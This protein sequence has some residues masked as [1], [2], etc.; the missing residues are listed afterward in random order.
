MKPCTCQNSPSQLC[1]AQ[2]KHKTHNVTARGN[3]FLQVKILTSYFPGDASKGLLRFEARDKIFSC[4]PAAGRCCLQ[5]S[6]FHNV[7]LGSSPGSL[8]YSF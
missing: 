7:S 3:L 1:V 4:S 5:C 2:V 6:G 8:S